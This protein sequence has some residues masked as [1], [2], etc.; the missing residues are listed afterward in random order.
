MGKGARLL[1]LVV[2]IGVLG[3]SHALAFPPPTESHLTLG[4][5]NGSV[6]TQKGRLVFMD[7]LHQGER[8]FVDELKFRW[9]DAVL[10]TAS[11]A[12]ITIASEHAPDLFEIRMWKRLRKSGYPAGK[13]VLLTCT[14]SFGSE[15]SL[16][17]SVSSEGIAW[18]ARFTMP[19]GHTYIAALG[20]WEDGT[21]EPTSVHTQQAVW[22]FHALS[23]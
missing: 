15:C 23:D 13:P 10:T 21:E 7:W 20:N 5:E 3:V 12:S 4:G 8:T 22:I 18:E 9:P 1:C 19:Q 14:T 11:A 16:V 6:A 17:P 2:A